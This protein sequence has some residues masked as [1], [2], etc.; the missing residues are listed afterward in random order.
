MIA[1]SGDVFL[2][3]HAVDRGVKDGGKAL[4]AWVDEYPDSVS[5]RVMSR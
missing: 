3:W 1:E 4:R 2:V 5:D